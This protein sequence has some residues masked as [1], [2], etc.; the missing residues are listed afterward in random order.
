MKY[1]GKRKF[2]QKKNYEILSLNDLDVVSEIERKNYQDYLRPKGNYYKSKSY[3]GKT[4]ENAFTAKTYRKAMKDIPQIEKDVLY[5]C[6]IECKSLNEVCKEL[7]KS[8]CEVLLLKESAKNH[9]KKNLNRTKRRNYKKKGG[10][11]HE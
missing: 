4:L 10:A 3:N 2:K 8:K 7:N 9:F 5:L 11:Y 6:V 1:F